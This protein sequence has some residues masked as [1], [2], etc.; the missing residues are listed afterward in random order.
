MW[1]MSTHKFWLQLQS[2]LMVAIN[3]WLNLNQA[4]YRNNDT[5]VAHQF[6]NN[7]MVYV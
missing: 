3:T 5:T 7:D 1:I 2:K 4:E 6:L